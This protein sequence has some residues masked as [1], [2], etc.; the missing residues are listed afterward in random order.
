[1]MTANSLG[2][3]N[4]WAVFCLTVSLFTPATSR[5]ELGPTTLPE[6]TRDSSAIV[7]AHVEKIVEVTINVG[8]SGQKGTIPWTGPIAI[9]VVERSILGPGVGQR[10]AIPAFATWTCD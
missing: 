5:S 1:M 2:K 9:A 4:L 6:L 10:I 3:S 7:V 8:E